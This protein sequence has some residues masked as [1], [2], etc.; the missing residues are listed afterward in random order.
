MMPFLRRWALV[1]VL[2]A[3]AAGAALAQ[4]PIVKYVNVNFASRVLTITGSNFGSTPSVTMGGTSLTPTITD[5]VLQRMTVTAPAGFGAANYALVVGNGYGTTTFNVLYAPPPLTWRGA[6]SSSTSYGMNDAV[7]F[8]GGSYL[9]RNAN[10]NRQPDTHPSDWNVLAA[11]P[12]APPHE[13]TLVAQ[14]GTDTGTVKVLGLRYIIAVAGIFPSNGGSGTGYSDVIL[15]E[16]RM[17]AGNFAPSGFMFCEGQ[18][19]QIQNNQALFALLGTQYGG[20]GITTFALPDLRA[21]AAVH[22]NQ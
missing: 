2:S 13:I 5:A 4:A 1:P 10:S 8:N 22:A 9:S 16:I 18:L 6:W 19:L 7:S 15:G 21:T 20:D 3:L 12:P 14:G 17:F 11:P